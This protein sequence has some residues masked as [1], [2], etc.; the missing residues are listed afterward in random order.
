MKEFI[1]AFAT[2]NAVKP[3]N[4]LNPEFPETIQ[5]LGF[6]CFCNFKKGIASDT[7]MKLLRTFIFIHLS[8]CFKFNDLIPPGSAYPCHTITE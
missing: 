6:S 7:N 8:H 3:G 4:G 1:I 2:E 5:T